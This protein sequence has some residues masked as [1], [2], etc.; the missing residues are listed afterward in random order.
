M[1]IES[2]G[3]FGDFSNQA[4]VEVAETINGILT[5]NA[6]RQQRYHNSITDTVKPPGMDDDNIDLSIVIGGDGTFLNVARLRAGRRAPILGVNLGRRGFL[7][8]VSV[9]EIEA[10]LQLVIQGRYTIEMRSLLVCDI[11]INKNTIS[12]ATALNDIVVHK[13]N[14]GRLIDLDIH[15]DGDFVTQLRADGVIVATPTGATAY[16]LSA[17][18]PILHPKLN[19]LEI[20]PI[21]P[22]TLTQRPIV[23]SDSSQISIKATHLTTGN[24]EVVLDGHIH[25]ELDGTETVAVRRSKNQVSM[26]RTPGHSYFNTLRQKLTWGV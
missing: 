8:D 15:A 2:V 17:G 5:A 21:S 22:H 16:A 6:I 13:S 26:V 19:A 3:I 18:G 23:F 7:T 24:A 12:T 11:V 14:S 4:V 10:S 25:A 9:D 1:G 20:V